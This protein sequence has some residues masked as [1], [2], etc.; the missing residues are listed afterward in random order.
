MQGCVN[1]YNTTLNSV[2]DSVSFLFPVQQINACPLM[3]VDISTALLE[4][5]H[6]TDYVVRYSNRGTV[7]A[8]GAEVKVKLNEFLIFNSAELPFTNE[9][10]DGE[11]YYVFNIGDVDPLETGSFKINVLVDFLRCLVDVD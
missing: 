7:T 4:K 10:I 9:N 6:Y 2:G 8:I 1:S 3:H 5:C 11:L